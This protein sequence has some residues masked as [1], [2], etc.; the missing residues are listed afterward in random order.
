VLRPAVG[1]VQRWQRRKLT[2]RERWDR[3]LPAEVGFWRKVLT[4]PT[5]PGRWKPLRSDYAWTEEAVYAQVAGRLPEGRVTVLDVG[6]GPIT[7]V[8]KV[9]PGRTFDIT[10]VDPLADAYNALLDE[11]G[12]VPFVRTQPGTG[13]HLLESVD[14]GTF[15]VAHASNSL[16]HTYDPALAIR[17]MVLAVKPGG[18]VLLRHERNE[19]VNE[20]YRRLH[21]WNFD[22][23]GTDFILWRPGVRR[24]LSRELADL[25]EG[26]VSVDGGWIVWLLRRHGES[27]SR[28]T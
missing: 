5:L 15:D 9:H 12:I 19:A 4:D 25:A 16:D 20:H 3:A 11:L 8:P 1:R 7:R 27:A 17:N 18:L 22:R 14:S 10:A 6:A 28:V 23:E 13:E 21:Q 2:D 26:E 24:N